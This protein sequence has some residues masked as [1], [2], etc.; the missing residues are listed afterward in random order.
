MIRVTRRGAASFQMARLAEGHQSLPPG[1]HLLRTAGTPCKR[2]AE[3]D[4]LRGSIMMLGEDKYAFRHQPPEARHAMAIG[5]SELFDLI[6]AQLT[7]ARETMI[8]W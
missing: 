7:Q 1:F 6:F 4:T 2:R 3:H 5:P 8:K